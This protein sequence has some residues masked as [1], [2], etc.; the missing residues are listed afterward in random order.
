MRFTK[1]Q[2]Y[3]LA[4]GKDLKQVMFGELFSLTGGLVAGLLLA[5]S[6]NEILLIPGLFIIIPGFMEMRGNIA[7]TMSA[8]LGSGLWLRVVR[9]T[10]KRNRLLK[11][12][13]LGAIALTIVVSFFLGVVAWAASCFAF[14]IN[15]PVLIA[16]S[17]IAALISNFIELPFTAATTFWL[18]RRGVDP[19]NV[20]GPYITTIGDI[21][22][23]VSL[24]ITIVIV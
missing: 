14:G 5:L 18:Y 15:N 22:S 12:N 6:L 10:W 16:I 17:V 2:R 8:R 21:V 23:V 4:T 9:P 11:G 24:L 7:G 13:M 3:E 19:N 1:Q 20:M